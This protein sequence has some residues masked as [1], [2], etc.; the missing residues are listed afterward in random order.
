MT[1]ISF[2][3]G[4]GE[5]VALIGPNGTEKSRTIDTLSTYLWAP[6]AP[7]PVARTSSELIPSRL[8]GPDFLILNEPTAGIDVEA[9]RDVW[10]EIHKDTRHGRGTLTTVAAREAHRHFSISLKRLWRELGHPF[11]RSTLIFNP[12]LPTMLYLPLFRTT[13]S[14]DLPGGNFAMWMAIGI[15]VHDAATSSANC[16]ASVSVDEANGWAHGVP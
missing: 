12:A 10:D 11:R 16:A 8:P 6:P 15:A 7:T 9:R 3:V 14:A 2:T 4:R 1:G 5:V 13:H